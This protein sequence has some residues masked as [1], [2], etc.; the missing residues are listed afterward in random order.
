VLGVGLGEDRADRGGDH[1]GVAFGHRGEHVAHEVHPAA[2][3]GRAEQHRHDRLLEAGVGVGDDQ[4]GAGEPTGLEG[5]QER[6]PEGAVLRVA[7]RA[8]EHLAV[9]VGGHAGGDHHRLGDD[10]AVDPRRAVGGVEEHV[11]KRGLGQRPVPE[12]THFFVE[13]G[14]DPAHLGLG[15]AGVGAQRADQI[16]DLAGGTPCR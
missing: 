9:P 10:P 5:A 11:G 16:V 4:L 2:L 1:L 8:A 14:A 7:D 12:G 3:P 15:D 13:V 6:G